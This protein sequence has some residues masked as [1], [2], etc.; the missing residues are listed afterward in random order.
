[1][2]KRLLSMLL[3]LAIMATM[4]VVPVSA[5]EEVATEVST[6][7]VDG[8]C[9]C[10]CGQKLEDITWK[11]WNVNA[12]GD[13]TA[14]H[15]YLD[16][17]YVQDGQKQIMAGD[18]VVL[19]LRGNTITSKSYSRLLL[20]YGRMHVMD[21]VGGGRFMS[22]TSGAAFGGV[23]MVSTNEVNDSVFELCSGIITRDDDNKG[24]R[25][26]GLVYLTN[27][28]TFRM[29]GGMLLNGS[30]VSTADP[31][32][33]E[34]GGC[35]AAFSKNATVEILGGK[36][37]GGESAGYGGN[38]Y[39]SGTTILKNCEIIG[40]VSAKSGGNIIQEGGSLTIENAIIRDGVANDTGA[41]G[42]GGNIYVLSSATM[43]VKN[44]TVRNGWSNSCGGNILCNYATM[45]LE[46]TTVKAGV[47]NNRGNNIYGAATS[48]GFTIRNCELAGDVAYVGKALALEGRVKIGLLN[49]GLKLS[50]GTEVAEALDAAKL[51][52]GSEIFVNAAAAFAKA[53]ANASYFKGAGRTVLTET[54]NGLVASVASDGELGGY[55]AHCGQQVA[56]K[57]FSTTTSLVQNCLHDK[58][59]DTDPAC[60]GKH[61]DDGHYY[62]TANQTKMAQYF[63]G[64]YVKDAGGSLAVRDVVIDL[65][66]YSITATSHRAFYLYL[67]G[68][69]GSNTLTLMD[70]VGNS[71]VSAGGAN[72]Q[73]GGVLYNETGILNIYGGK[74]VYDASYNRNIAGGGVILNAGTFNMYGG[75]LDASAFTY[76]NQ[77][78]DS[79]T[80]SYYGGALYA[81][82]NRTTNISAGRLIGGV[83][84]SGGCAY[85]GYNNKVN[86]T[87]GQFSGGES[88]VGSGGSIRMYGTS[89]YAKNKFNMS[90]ASVRGGKVSVTGAGGGNLSLAY[91]TVDLSGTYI[92]GGYAAA[93]GGNI[94]TGAQANVT[95]TDCIIEGGYAAG[96]SGNAHLSST[97]TYT[98]WDN[99]LVLNGSATY[100]GNINSGNGYNT[101]KGCQILYGKARITYGGNIS[102]VSGNAVTSNYTKLLA[103]SEGHENLVAGGSAKTYGGNICVISVLD[104]QSVKLVNGH[105]G[106]AGKDLFM[107]KASK[108]GLLTI[109]ADITGTFYAD[110]NKALYGA[111]VY[112]Q[113]VVN[114]VCDTLHANIIVEQYNNALLCAKDGALYVGAIAVT[115]GTNYQWFTDTASAVTAC[116]E[117]SYVKLFIAQD[118]VLTKDCVVDICG[119]EINV[120]GAYTLYGMDSSGDGFDAP[121]GKVILAEETKLAT[122]ITMNGKR[123]IATINAGEATFHRLENR[124]SGVALRPSDDG[125][126]Y[127][128]AFGCDETLAGDI[129]SYGVAVSLVN[130]PGTDFMTDEDTLF[131]AFE[132]T[133]LQG[134]ANVTGTLISGIMD[135]EN[136]A[137]LNSAYGQMPIFAASYLVMKDGTVVLSDSV[138]FSLRD[139]MTTVDD[140]ID[141]DPLNYRRLTNPMRAFYDKWADNGMADWNFKKIITPKEDDVI[142]VLMIGNSFCYYYVEELVGLAAADGIK[143]R[144][145]NVY[146]SGCY[147]SQHYNWWLT[148]NEPYQ[149]FDTT[150]EGGRKQTNNVSLEW[151]LAQGEWD[152]IS[153]QTAS[154]AT[155]GVKD[156]VQ[157]VEDNK[158]YL[159]TFYSYFREQFPKAQLAWHQ[160]WS[161]AVGTAT[162][163]IV[164]TPETQVAKHEVNKASAK[165]ICDMYDVLQINSG[166]AWKIIRD[167]GYD[168]LCARIGKGTDHEGDYY[169]DGDIGGGQYLN[170]CVWYETITGMSVIGN[171]YRPVY[172]YN[173]VEIPLNSEITYEML[174]E[175]AHQAVASIHGERTN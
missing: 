154:A 124:V 146:Y 75:T 105:A 67:G 103:D 134:G 85:F 53:G 55:C 88:N 39:S 81:T 7:P 156:P 70:S 168:K 159:D 107:D 57:A 13:P 91:G 56:W 108:Y 35:V 30:T 127:T 31:S 139:L 94:L 46:N 17:D 138:A 175:A 62:L 161:Y 22:K 128:G 89:T 11:P 63:I 166:D 95:F 34:H 59:D 125:I 158:L 58:L 27:T 90:N 40:G 144:V 99:C 93:Y 6:T 10:G 136:A 98:T 74:Y 115:D 170:A 96:Q 52:E 87:G 24:S 110:F 117:N 101:F 8:G 4:V 137:D 44:A 86:I 145:C 132:G 135:Q 149:F 33:K 68:T 21:T 54:E 123:Y 122:D 97:N 121:A 23:V 102:A 73:G 169:H 111:G 28:A 66:G 32:K 9:P 131:T 160:T 152:Y 83:A 118:V 29:T 148:G 165:M 164:T 141:S 5:A 20:V 3:M 150:V 153:L 78:T 140:L 129:A 65:A 114:T 162:N 109:G 77:S 174:Q 157:V 112:G 100:G 48:K 171:T 106:T 173:G 47:A 113:A 42:G 64:A 167:G 14:G 60:T 147:L 80:Y 12:E 142:D 37:V 172:K 41:S 143:M 43:T 82:N 16:G 151:C 116:D 1:M 92:E 18:R 126:Y 119:Q 69:I 25:N 61:I 84:D 155:S 36:I 26:G 38:I 71:V 79:K 104:M 72:N 45:T 51:T 163:G 76:T 133:T 15:Y 19:D 130:A 50:Y 49:Y 2:K 120:S